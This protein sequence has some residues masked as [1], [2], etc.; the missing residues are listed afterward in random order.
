[1]SIPSRHPEVAEPQPNRSMQNLNCHPEL[2]SGSSHCDDEGSP[3]TPTLSR[4][5]R[6]KRVAFTLAEVLITLAIIGVVAAMTIPTLISNYKKNVVETKLAKF[7]TTINQALKLSSVDNGPYETWDRI[8]TEDVS[9]G[10]GNLLWRRGTNTLEWFN[11]YL[12]PY[13]RSTNVVVDENDRDG[14]IAVYLMDGSLLYFEDSSWLFYPDAKDFETSLQEDGYNNRDKKLCGIKY[15]T[16]KF[17]YDSSTGVAPYS[18]EWN[19]ER[20][21]LLTRSNVGCNKNAT[22]EA[23]YCTK[24]IQLNNWKI[25]EDYPFKF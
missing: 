15:F 20:E 17:L 12:K 23:A 24:L 22:N 3:L 4:R 7:Y 11:K 10:D 9:D 18:D 8:L 5:A 16:F 13:I 2:V 1:V 14:K 6:G 25:P 21:F 19:G